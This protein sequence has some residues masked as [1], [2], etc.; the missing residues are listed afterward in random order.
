MA[1]IKTTTEGALFNVITTICPWPKILKDSVY[2]RSTPYSKYCQWSSNF[3][4]LPCAN[5][6]IGTGI[7]WIIS[8]HSLWPCGIYGLCLF[9]LMETGFCLEG[10][11]W[12]TVVRWC[13]KIRETGI[14]E[15]VRNKWEWDNGIR[16][17]VRKSVSKDSGIPS[18]ALFSA[19]FTPLLITFL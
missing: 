16:L 4:C 5:D 13:S 9:T 3:W 12:W 11:E 14:E 18:T 7:K 10:K 2:F 17:K 1:I 19:L 8:R 15:M 6:E